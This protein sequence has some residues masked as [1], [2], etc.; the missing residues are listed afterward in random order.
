MLSLS[1]A[2]SGGALQVL[3]LGA[4]SDDIEIGCSGTVLT[5]LE[6]R[7]DVEVT[8]VVFSAEGRREDE[9]LRSADRLL[10]AAGARSVVLKPFRDGF[11]PFQGAEIKEAFEDLKDKVSPDV[12]LT[13]HRGDLHQD[14]RMISDLTW[15]TFRDH[16]I[17]EY[18][19]PKYDGDL[20]SPNVYVPL[21]ESVCRRKITNLLETFSTQK[22]RS[23]FSEDLF[24]A[25]MRLRGMESRAPE[26]LAEGFHSRKV[27]LG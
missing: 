16:M 8:W 4:H 15:N 3:C 18:E 22:G 5:L 27:V 24:R 25:L 6:A 13:H 21:T 2:K 14:H 20:V 10:A 11:F 19:I 12:I 26:G 9:A 17:L 23:W 1:L 7:P